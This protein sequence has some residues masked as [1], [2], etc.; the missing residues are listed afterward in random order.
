[1]ANSNLNKAKNAKNDEFYTRFDDIQ[2]EIEA[3]LEYDPNVFRGKVVYCNCDDP[4]ESNFFKYFALRFK[5]LGLRQLIATSYHP[6]P[7]ANTELPLF[8]DD[9]TLVPVKSRPMINANR[10]IIN[11]VGDINGDGE[12]NLKDIAQQ[13]RENKNNEWAPLEDNGDFRSEECVELLKRADIVVTNPP[14]SL[15]REYIAQL[16]EYD[17]RFLIIGNKNTIN[18]KE[19][20]PLIKDNKMWV[21]VTPMSK[22]ILFDVPNY[23]SKNLIENKKEGSAY[24]IIDGVVRAR[25]QAVWF[26]NLDHGRKHKQLILLSEKE[27]IKYSTK[28]PFEKYDNYNAIN[29]DE[30]KNIPS[31]YEGVM[32]V[33]VTFLAKY[34]PDQFEI[35]G[36]DFQVKEGLLPDLVNRKWTGKLDKGYINGKRLYARIFIKHK[37]PKKAKAA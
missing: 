13:L 23:F 3:Y 22:D 18:C 20:F 2:K 30:V 21:G 24:K 19:I 8:G 33:P 27:A 14:F 28:K 5:T 37:K 17:K 15:F 16:I 26:T 34:N 7:I 12:F 31:D 9:K 25:A 29:I 10:F 35:L 11:D 32:G 4:Y 6:S 36:M 1:M